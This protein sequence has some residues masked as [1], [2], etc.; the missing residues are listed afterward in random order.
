V[1]S[2]NETRRRVSTQRVAMER[3][4]KPVIVA[5]SL[6]CLQ[7]DKRLTVGTGKVS[8]IDKER[9]ISII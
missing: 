4:P 2:V 5:G 1:N 9:G 8:G 6:N 3:D 7:I